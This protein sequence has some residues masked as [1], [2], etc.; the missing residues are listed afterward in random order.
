MSVPVSE[1]ITITAGTE[2]PSVTRLKI[3]PNITSN[4]LNIE[5]GINKAVTIRITDA[6]G[7]IIRIIETDQ[8]KVTI[9]VSNLRPGV[10]FVVM[11]SGR[12]SIVEKFV[13]GKS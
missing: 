8:E 10:Y 3:Y 4:I 2:K 7:K 1:L 13:V 5:T 9:N 6:N 12:D 11:V